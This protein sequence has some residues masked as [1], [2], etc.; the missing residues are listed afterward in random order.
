[1]SL[2]FHFLF[3]SHSSC[4]LGDS[5]KRRRKEETLVSFCRRFTV[6][7][8]YHYRHESVEISPKKKGCSFGK[9]RIRENTC[10]FAAKGKKQ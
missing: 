8:Q 4:G 6:V 9:R 7:A 10:F 1:G 2:S 5:G 3:C